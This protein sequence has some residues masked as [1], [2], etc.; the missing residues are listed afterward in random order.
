MKYF[1]L[2]HQYFVMEKMFHLTVSEQMSCCMRGVVDIF[3]ILSSLHSKGNIIIVPIDSHRAMLDS[4]L[5][6]GYEE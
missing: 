3:L 5:R 2:L 1:I 4:H 6:Y